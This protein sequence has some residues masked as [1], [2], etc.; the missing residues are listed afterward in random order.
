MRTATRAASLHAQIDPLRWAFNAALLD[1]VA[2]AWEE[3]LD[4]LRDRGVRGLHHLTPPC[5]M[6]SAGSPV[7][8]MAVKVHKLLQMPLPCLPCSLL[9]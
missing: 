5:A 6:L 3:A 2:G 9:H 4:R 7:H 1:C 8:Q